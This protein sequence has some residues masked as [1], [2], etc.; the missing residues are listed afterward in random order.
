MKAARKNLYYG[1]QGMKFED[2]TSV[3]RALS[4]YRVGGL[5][6]KYQKGKVVDSGDPRDLRLAKLKGEEPI[7]YMNDGT[8]LYMK[9]DGTI[10]PI[11]EP[12]KDNLF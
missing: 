1:K 10:G 3:R 11:N 4:L 12:G 8:P 2:L 6:D 5:I 7:S 9:G